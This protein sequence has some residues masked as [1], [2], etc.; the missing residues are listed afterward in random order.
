M[1]PR[2]TV[3]TVCDPTITRRSIDVILLTS[4]GDANL[5][6]RWLAHLEETAVHVARF[7]PLLG[8]IMAATV[9]ASGDENRRTGSRSIRS[10]E[11]AG[12]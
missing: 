6:R 9:L 10:H 12:T 1:R 2:G 5:S 4:Y 3:I 11:K 7:R 8:M